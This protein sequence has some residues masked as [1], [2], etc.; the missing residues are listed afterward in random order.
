ME[1]PGEI[2][3]LINSYEVVI[4]RWTINAWMVLIAIDLNTIYK[5]GIYL[6]LTECHMSAGVIVM[7]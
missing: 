3:Y 6:R 2:N 7:L 1:S 5:I 4:Y